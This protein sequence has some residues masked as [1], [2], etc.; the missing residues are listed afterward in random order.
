M[1]LLAILDVETTHLLPKDG[2]I[3][4]IGV[5]RYSVPFR[6][7]VDS[8]SML[9]DDGATENPA[10]KTNGI[11]VEMAKEYGHHLATVATALAHHLMPCDAI[12]AH[13]ARFD[14]AWTEHHLESLPRKPW[15]CTEYDFEWEHGKPGSSLISLAVDHGVPVIAAHRALTDCS[16]I[17][18]I[19]STYTPE[20]LDVM[21]ARATRPRILLQSK[22][23]FDKNE[24]AK[25]LGFRWE[26]GS[27][28]WLKRQAN[29][30]PL[31]AASWPIV[32]VT[33]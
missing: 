32:E 9:V 26:G 7:V 15:L 25:A 16:L 13:N 17:A 1:R 20:A 30:D 2:H 4:E 27:K 31:P 10:E 11:P 29:D 12:L 19:L 6:C 5:V 21:L 14:E 28:R 22:H 24:E 23:K 8:W 3:L 18:G 33:T